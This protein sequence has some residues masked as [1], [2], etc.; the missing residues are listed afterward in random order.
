MGG[1]GGEGGGGTTSKVTR[2]RQ[3][4]AINTTCAPSEQKYKR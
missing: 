4:T 1:R 2:D 3:L